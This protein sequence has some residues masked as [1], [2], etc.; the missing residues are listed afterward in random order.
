[1]RLQNKRH[2]FNM[3]KSDF[4]TE[5]FRFLSVCKY[6]VIWNCIPF[7]WCLRYFEIGLI[8][9][10]FFRLWFSHPFTDFMKMLTDT[11]S[12]TV[13]RIRSLFA[14]VRP[15]CFTCDSECFRQIK[16]AIW[17]VYSMWWNLFLCFG[18]LNLRC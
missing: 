6:C 18:N 5:K 17:C 12:R 15:C 7:K 14:V 9:F 13:S 1:M 16:W 3:E 2:N 4:A 10:P 11:W 8:S